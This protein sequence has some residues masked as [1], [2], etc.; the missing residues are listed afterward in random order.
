MMDCDTTPCDSDVCET[1]TLAEAMEPGGRAVVRVLDTEETELVE[2]TEAVP[3]KARELVVVDTKYGVDLA[4]VIGPVSDTGGKAWKEVRAVKR[5]ASDEDYAR[6]R[7]HKERAAEAHE[8]CVRKIE[9]HR[10]P[11]KLV[12]AHYVLNDSK[13]L[14]FFT[15]ESRIDFRGLVK[16]LVAELRTRVELRQVGVR[17]ESR[18]LGGNGVCGRVYCCHGVSDRLQPVSI[19]MAKTQNL[20]LNSTKISGPCGRLLCCL[21]YEHALYEV[22]RKSLPKEGARIPFDGSTFRVNE[23]NVLTHRVRLSSPDGR[24]LDLGPGELVFDQDKR[25]WTITVL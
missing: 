18:M 9:R 19:K 17:D 15:A 6:Y 22:E 13:V 7:S 24:Y 4:R 12:L 25:K 1:K 20:S 10:L 3:L 14:F 23:I 2:S 16:D 21:A 11:M 8:V 5:H